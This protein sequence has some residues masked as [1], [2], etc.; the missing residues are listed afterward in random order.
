[1]ADAEALSGSPMLGFN[2]LSIVRQIGLMVG[3][4]ASVAIGFAV[5]LWSQKA[6]QRVL[7]SNLTFADANQIIEQ[8]RLY[9]VP[10]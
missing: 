5:V 4:A 7:F 10:H 9:N 2:K 3:L 6:E 1:M 8:L